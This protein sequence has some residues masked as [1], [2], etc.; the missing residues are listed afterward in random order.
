MGKIRSKFGKM[1]AAEPTHTSNI[2]RYINAKIRECGDLMITNFHRN[3]VSKVPNK[4]CPCKCLAFIKLESISRSE[5]NLCYPQ[6]KLEEFKYHVKNIKKARRITKDFEKSASG[7]SGS[8][9][10]SE[11]DVGSDDTDEEYFRKYENNE[12]NE[13]ENN[14]SN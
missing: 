12:S 2:H 11:S 7:E 3:K 10:N 1:F 13:S 9:P 5:E 6:T 4:D 8:E 14:E